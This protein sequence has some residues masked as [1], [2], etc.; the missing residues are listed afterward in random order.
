MVKR[1]NACPLKKVQTMQDNVNI[2]YEK[3]Q[4]FNDTDIIHKLSHQELHIKFWVLHTKN[5][6]ENAV[7]WSDITSYPVPVVI[8][9]FINNFRY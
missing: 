1:K 7:K 9:R 4:L 6:P 3:I 2:E 8:E 5:S